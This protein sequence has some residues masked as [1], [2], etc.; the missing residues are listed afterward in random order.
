MPRTLAEDIDRG[1]MA[2]ALARKRGLETAG[3]GAVMA[4]LK[5]Q[6][7]VAWASELAEQDLVLTTPVS[8]VEKPRSVVT[9]GGVSHYASHYLRTITS[10]RIGQQTGGWGMID[11]QWYKGREGDA[12]YALAA[13]RGAM[14]AVIGGERRGK[15]DS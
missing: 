2:I 12:L 5:R 13:L 15:A 10:A 4:D 3:W 11:A 1:R 6:T 8:Y 9:T 7:L 14:S